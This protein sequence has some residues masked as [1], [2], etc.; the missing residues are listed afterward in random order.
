MAYNG[1]CI[2]SDFKI[3]AFD[4]GCSTAIDFMRGAL[5]FTAALSCMERL[6]MSMESSVKEIMIAEQIPITRFE[7]KQAGLVL[8]TPEFRISVG[9]WAMR[10][11][12]MM[13]T[14]L[15]PTLISIVP[16]MVPLAW[17]LPVA[18]YRNWGFC[19]DRFRPSA[20]Q[21]INR[22]YSFHRTIL[23]QATT[24]L[25]ARVLWRCAA[26]LIAMITTIVVTTFL[27]R[28]GAEVAITQLMEQDNRDW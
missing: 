28:F 19:L 5:R 4:L 15:R 21:L 23:S 12:A 16:K 7:Q 11:G 10:N 6:F 13:C 22:L 8:G 24:G 27:W 17:R 14:F 18:V 25:S 26:G 1:C 3:E 20:W 9:M 2:C